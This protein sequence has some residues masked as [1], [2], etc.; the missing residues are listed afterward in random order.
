MQLRIQNFRI[1]VGND[2]GTGHFT[3]AGLLDIES[4][5]F[6]GALIIQVHLEAQGFDV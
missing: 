6:V 1:L 5:G 2:V 4:L 3:F